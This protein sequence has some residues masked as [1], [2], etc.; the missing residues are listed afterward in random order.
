MQ[1][2]R[3]YATPSEPARKFPMGPVYAV[4]AAGVAAG[5]IYYWNR[6]G[7]PAR[8]AS[9]A[10]KSAINPA[11]NKTFTGGDQGFVD[12]KLENVEEINHNTKRFRFALPE[13][14]D[15]SGLSTACARARPLL[16]ERPSGLTG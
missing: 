2:V 13:K 6:S 7:G 8:A 15:V 14:E 16:S 10:S 11:G 9:P 3:R 5:T 12:L 1:G 4:A